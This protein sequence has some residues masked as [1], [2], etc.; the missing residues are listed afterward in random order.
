MGMERQWRNHI[1]HA[2]GKDQGQQNG[3]FQVSLPHCHHRITNHGE[4]LHFDENYIT[5]SRNTF[6]YC[7]LNDIHS[8]GIKHFRSYSSVHFPQ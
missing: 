8:Q 6:R 3:D 7:Q 2:L 5:H 4:T 1:C